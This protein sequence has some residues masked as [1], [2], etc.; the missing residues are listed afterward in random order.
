MKSRYANRME[1]YQQGLSDSRIAEAVGVN[2]Q[3]ITSWRWYWKL[4][5][6]WKRPEYTGVRPKNS[7]GCPM[8]QALSDDQCEVVRMFLSDLVKAADACKGRKDVMGF[9]REWAALNS[10]GKRAVG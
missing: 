8:E 7:A 1:M 2:R 9:M 3:K 5:N 6:R 10:E 4:P